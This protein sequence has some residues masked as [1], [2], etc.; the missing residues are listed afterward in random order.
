ML[1]YLYHQQSGLCATATAPTSS[2]ST[3]YTGSHIE[4]Q[5]CGPLDQTPP[6]A[7]LFSGVNDKGFIAVLFSGDLA[8]TLSY[9][10]SASTSESNVPLSLALFPSPDNYWYYD[11]VK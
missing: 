1:G 10:G 6:E 4:L 3:K 8:G 2:T 7:Q 9:Y 5:P 11:C